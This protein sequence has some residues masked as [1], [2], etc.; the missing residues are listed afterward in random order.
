MYATNFS[1]CLW[2]SFTSFELFRDQ[3]A[4]N[5]NDEAMSLLWAAMGR[6]IC[7][8]GKLQQIV[9]KVHNVDPKLV[10][11]P[12]EITKLEDRVSS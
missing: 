6:Q 11:L 5:L 1:S 2:H 7:D 9:Q 4:D 12:E 3:S 10:V 8:D